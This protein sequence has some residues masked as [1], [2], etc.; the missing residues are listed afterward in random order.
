MVVMQMVVQVM[1][2]R[3]AVMQCRCWHSHGRRRRVVMA[4]ATRQ[5]S[6]RIVTV[7]MDDLVRMVVRMMMQ[8]AVG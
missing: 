4:T 5:H 3:A 7:V 2:I 8:I 6:S 1:V